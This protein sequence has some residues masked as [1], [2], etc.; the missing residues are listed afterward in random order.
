MNLFRRK[1]PKF[2]ALPAQ[3]AANGRIEHWHSN[4][5]GQV[6]WL[7]VDGTAESAA[8]RKRF[9]LCL[10]LSLAAVI[11]GGM[12]LN[13]ALA[14]HVVDSGVVSFWAMA[15]LFAFLVWASARLT[16]DIR[17][18]T[19]NTDT[20]VVKLRDGTSEY[21]MS[22]IVGVQL[23]QVNQQ[24]IDAERRERRHQSDPKLIEP[25]SMDLTL[26]TGLGGIDLGSVF[27]IKDAQEIANSVNMALQFMKGRTG[28]GEGTVTDPAYQ[29]RGK[30]AGQIPA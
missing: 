2:E 1:Q 27:G 13:K 6:A 5:D 20:L 19:V 30:T 24:R 10:I 12:F 23:H 14:A 3:I 29:Y 17:K 22:Q 21:A 28:T 7:V 16:K 8:S 15:F 9:G 11:T 4:G 25:Y 26:E 18:F